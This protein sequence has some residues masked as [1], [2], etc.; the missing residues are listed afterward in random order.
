MD[1]L[2]NYAYENAQI[3]KERTNILHDK[4]IT[5]RKFVVG[6]QVLL[7]NSRLRLFPNKLHS[8]WSGPFMVKRVFS[9]GAVKIINDDNRTF[10]ANSQ[11]LN[12]YMRGD[13]N[14]HEAS[15]NLNTIE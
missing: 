3:Y 8:R 5:R 11:K 15:F 10:K 1:E 13:F 4:H 7:Y 9:H 12:H 2:R 14:K 6:Q